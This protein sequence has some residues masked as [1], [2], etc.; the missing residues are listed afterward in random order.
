MDEETP[1]AAQVI[2]P[3]L[4]D[5]EDGL[6][7]PL[8]L[9]F[10]KKADFRRAIP[11]CRTHADEHKFSHLHAFPENHPCQVA[12]CEHMASYLAIV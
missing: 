4:P 10:R 7:P 11:I 12:M 9:P 3:P 8:P 5:S 6:S 1:E 2:P